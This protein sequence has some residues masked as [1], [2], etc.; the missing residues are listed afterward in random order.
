MTERN[1]KQ[2]QHYE[3]MTNKQL[4]AEREHAWGIEETL[5]DS[6]GL[7]TTIRS[8]RKRSDMIGAVV[9]GRMLRGDMQ[10]ALNGDLLR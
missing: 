2:I 8:A 9:M 4:L 3:S 1:V 7:A 10:F 5:G 6:K